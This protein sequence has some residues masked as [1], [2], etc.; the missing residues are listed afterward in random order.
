MEKSKQ[1][2]L[3]KQKERL[4]KIQELEGIFDDLYKK[5]AGTLV[6]LHQMSITRMEMEAAVDQL[7]ND[8]LELKHRR[9]T[10]LAEQN[11]FVHITSVG[12]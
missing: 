4:I 2:T 9:G 12:N 5:K 10:T 11:S 8:L 6:D 1:D 3:R 7:A